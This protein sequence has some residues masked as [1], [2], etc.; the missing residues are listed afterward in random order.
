MKMD[1]GLPEKEI[2]DKVES[3]RPAVGVCHPD[4][5]KRIVRKIDCVVMPLVCAQ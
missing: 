3:N 4:E 2:H 5:E 1:G